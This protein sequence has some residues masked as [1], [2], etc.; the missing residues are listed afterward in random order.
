LSLIKKLLTIKVSN[1]FSALHEEL[2]NFRQREKY[3][4]NEFKELQLS[5]QNFHLPLSSA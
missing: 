1:Y 4:V 5:V 2:N 3:E